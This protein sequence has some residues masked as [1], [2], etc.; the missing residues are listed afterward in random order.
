[1]P[2]WLGSWVPQTF[3]GFAIINGFTFAVDLALLALLYDTLHVPHPV[4]ISMGYGVA[5]SLAFILNRWLNFH[6]HGRVGGQVGKY[7]VVVAVNYTAL[8]LGLGSG[9]TAL[10]VPYLLARMMAGLAEAIWMYSAMRWWVFR[11][12]AAPRDVGAPRPAMTGPAD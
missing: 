3:I 4:A 8:I 5:F 12:V 11:H 1:M 9:M 10:G 7:V 2:A 6:A